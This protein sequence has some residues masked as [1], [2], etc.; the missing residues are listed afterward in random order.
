MKG[1]TL[2]DMDEN[3]L[4][5]SMN[6]ETKQPMEDDLDHEEEYVDHL[7]QF[8]FGKRNQRRNNNENFI[9]GDSDYTHGDWF[10]KR[11]ET[12]KSFNLFKGKSARS[13]SP[14]S[15]HMRSSGKGKLGQIEDILNNI[16]YVD[17]MEKID[18]FITATNQLKPLYKD[19][20][21]IMN[22]FL[23]KK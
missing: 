23:Q 7:T 11:K 12:Q 18:A 15:F 20:K 9:N 10:I 4:P 22:Q 3:S 2:L 6:K 1:G 16:D 8:M 13:G 14:F 21:S 17:L 19:A 5:H